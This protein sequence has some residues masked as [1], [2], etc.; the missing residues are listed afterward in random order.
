[1]LFECK[2]VSF[3]YENQQVIKDLSFQVQEGEYVCVVGENGS[4]KSTLIKGLL[5]LIPAGS[6][7]VNY[8]KEISN[9]VIG[10]LPQ[11][12]SS[13]KDFP[14]TVWEVILS[15][16]LST[17]KGRFFYSK[18]DKE[19]ARRQMRHLELENLASRSFGELS[20]GQQQRVLI[21][22]ALC[23]T[24]SLLILDEP[25]TGLDPAVTRELYE[26]LEKLNKKEHTAIVMVL[27]EHFHMQIKFF[28]LVRKAT[29]LE[30]AESIV[31]VKRESVCLERLS[32]RKKKNESDYYDVSIS[33]YS[34]STDSR[35]AC[36]ALC[37]ASWCMPCA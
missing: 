36:V 20:G 5:G 14:A 17:R 16:C 7:Q 3:G 26:I 23:A 37:G 12:T 33:I 24:E 35:C 34:K 11:Q 22:R 9:H 32:E 31:Q 8:E 21:A 30:R 4:G 28:I 2:K 15:G 1:M 18:E 19:K 29:F 6:G 13:Q 27:Q 10:Y 25:V